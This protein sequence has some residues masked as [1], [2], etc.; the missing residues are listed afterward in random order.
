MGKEENKLTMNEWVKLTPSAIDSSWKSHSTHAIIAQNLICPI[1]LGRPFL[2][3]N[4]IVVDHEIPSCISKRDG[5]NLLNSAI[6]QLQETTKIEQPKLIQTAD[7][8]SARMKYQEVLM[9]EL[10]QCTKKDRDEPDGRTEKQ[11]LKITLAAMKNQ[12]EMLAN[13]EQLKRLNEE[14][15]KKFAD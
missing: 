12:V 15:R 1:I 13:A 4:Q 9:T 14:M 8:T 11:H 5:Y 3:I 7:Q 6:P 2:K 10:L